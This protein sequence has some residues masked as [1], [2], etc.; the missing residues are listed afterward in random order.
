MKRTSQRVL[1][2]FI[3]LSL[4]IIVYP[5]GSFSI[6]QTQT[7][8]LKVFS[9]V[10]DVEIYVDEKLVGKDTVEIKDILAG[11]HYV[12]IVRDGKVLYSEVANV[13]SGLVTT[14]L[15]KESQIPK[16]KLIKPLTTQEAEYK[17]EKLEIFIQGGDWYPAKGGEKISE[18]YFATL[19]NDKDVVDRI[20]GD[21][22]AYRSQLDFGTFFTVFGVIGTIGGLFLTGDAMVYTLTAGIIS[23]TV[24]IAMIDTA[25]MPHGHYM[26]LEYAVK[27]ATEYNLELKKKLNLPEDYDMPK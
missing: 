20:D 1:S 13:S 7:G 4:L 27:K 2:V 16:E 6:A 23:L 15:V 8:I 19:I 3:I 11:S 18:Y 10:K 5:S 9:E 12:K 21:W 24:G 17:K 26:S 22:R 14:V 25:K